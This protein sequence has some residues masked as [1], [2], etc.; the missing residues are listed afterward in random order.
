MTVDRLVDDL[1]WLID[2][3]SETGHERVLRD[4]IAD[5]LAAVT[6][7]EIVN[8]SL[9]AGRVTGRP[10]IDLYGHLDTV[11]VNGNLP[12]ALSNG[13][14]LGL[15]SSDMKAGLALM[16]AA[17]EHPAIADGPF[18][19]VAVFYDREEGPSEENGLEGVLDAVSH[20]AAADLAVV[21]EPTDNELQLGCQGTMNATVTFVGEAAHSARPWLGDNAVSKAGEWLSDMHRRVARD[22]VVAGLTFKETFVVTTARGGRARNVIPDSFELNVNHRYPPDRSVAE[23]EAILA[24]VCAAADRF[25]VIDRALAAPIPADNEHVDR[26]KASGV[27]AVTAKTAWTDVARLTARGIDAVNFGPGEVALAHRA[28]ESVAVA[29]LEQG[30]AVLERFLTT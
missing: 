2:I 26:L 13:R 6:D 27:A 28:D 21:M 16:L 19:V 24:E 5:R 29:A 15:G 17:L 11:P 4:A 7:V 14:V 1:L 20:L 8:E 10:R 9:V 22:V 25:E 30:W 3:P 23:A 12:G 18:D